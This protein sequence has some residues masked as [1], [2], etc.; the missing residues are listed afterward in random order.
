MRHRNKDKKFNRDSKARR[1]LFKGLV[2]SLVEHGSIVT[3]QA[4]AKEIKRLADKIIGKAKDDSLATRRL[5]H[6]FFGTRDVVNTLVD[7]IAPVF[8]DRTSGFTTI[9]DVGLRR[10]DNTQLSK[11][12]LATTVEAMGTLKPAVKK[13]VAQVKVVA[14]KKTV[15]KKKAQ[16]QES[17]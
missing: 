1:A 14:P 12:A 8:A 6:K 11:L 13:T 16:V 17:K 2:R 3:T 9:S 15:A 7:K 10:G 5:L 4:K